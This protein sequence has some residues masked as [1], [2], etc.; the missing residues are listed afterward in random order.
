MTDTARATDGKFVPA[1][2]KPS[3]EPGPKPTFVELDI[4]NLVIDSKYQRKITRAGDANIRKIARAFSWSRF[5]CLLV[6]GPDKIGD[7]A[8]MDGQ[9]RIEALK[10]RP[11]LGTKVPCLVLQIDMAAEQA[12]IFV[13]LNKDRVNMTGI[14]V[15]WAKHAKGEAFTNTVIE[16][17]EKSGFTISRVG[18][19]VQKAG[20]S[21]AVRP[22]LWAINALGTDL[23]VRALSVLVRGQ[24][25][26]ENALVTAPIKAIGRLYGLNGSVID[27]DHMIACLRDMDMD[28]VR[29]TARNLKSAFGG[30]IENAVLKLFIQA[31]NKGKHGPNRLPEN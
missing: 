8:V 16:V 30:N 26:C 29:E 25:G 19:G 14:N 13:S 4:E 17:A 15:F 22:I 23:A 21:I 24:E 5:G 11:D 31:Y 1:K 28:S 10:L 27:D 18:S 6:G 7:Y 12:G 20:N 9:H 3:C 2:I